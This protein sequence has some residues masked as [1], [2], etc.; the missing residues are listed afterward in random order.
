[1]SRA[2]PHTRKTSRPKHGRAFELMARGTILLLLVL[3]GAGAVYGGYS[4]MLD[5]SGNSL[6]LPSNLLA[7]TPFTDYYFP[8]LVLLFLNGVLSLAIAL[9]IL[10]SARVFPEL[11]ILQGIVLVIWIVVQMAMV[12]V[13]YFLDYVFSGVGILLIV[14]GIVLWPEHRRS[15][16]SI[17]RH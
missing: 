5:P 1:M 12:R 2:K 8:G 10:F 4:L 16:H 15:R 13:T 6:Q 9:V 14:L 17:V 3:N 7:S 11:V